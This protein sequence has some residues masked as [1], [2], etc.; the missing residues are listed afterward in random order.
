MDDDQ[1]DLAR[2]L[3]ASIRAARRAIQLTLTDV[4]A[5][6]QLSQP[7]LSQIENG[8]VMPSVINLHRIAQVLG[9][10][11]HDLLEQGTR[12]DATVIHVDDSSSY[13]LGPGAVMRFCTAGSRSMACNEVIADPRSAAE[14]PTSHNGEELLYVIS[15]RIRFVIDDAEHTLEPGSTIYYTASSPHQWFN[16]TEDT[17]KFLFICTPPGF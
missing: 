8:N 10:T 7:F 12:V 9:T 6:S 3:G 13:S 4:A 16:D 14:S 11:A 17:A 2:L 5:R 15:G 1:R